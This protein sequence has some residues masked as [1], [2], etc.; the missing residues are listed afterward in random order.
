M[1]DGAIEATHFRSDDEIEALVRDFESGAL[2]RERWT[3]HA[4]LVV[5]L[6]YVHRYNWEVAVRLVR[7]RIKFYNAC[8]GVADTPTGGYHETITVFWL[9]TVRDFHD[10]T[11][12]PGRPLAS[13]ANEMLLRLGDKNLP[14]KY[15]SRERLMSPAAR[16]SF[17]A[18]DVAE[19][20]RKE[21]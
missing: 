13:L 21:S 14:L 10:R 7:A 6:W 20:S 5:A 19:G 11:F 8:H 1:S 4:H 18:P 9:R 16:T 3:H 15:Y 12:T 17:V 2:P